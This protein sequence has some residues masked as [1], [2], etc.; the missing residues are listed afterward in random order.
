MGESYR[1]P[2]RLTMVITRRK[3]A[4]ALVP[5]ALALLVTL[6]L[7]LR[8]GAL[9]RSNHA[10]AAEVDTLDREVGHL[11]KVVIT[12][13]DMEDDGER[14]ARLLEVRECV[15]DFRRYFIGSDAG[16]QYEETFAMRNELERRCE[17]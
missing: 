14:V 7:G 1:R 4:L 11:E 16:M 8:A 10:L 6:G 2:S 3:A 9:E 5:A 15:A 13:N 17:R 12:M